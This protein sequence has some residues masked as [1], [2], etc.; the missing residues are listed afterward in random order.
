VTSH[1]PIDD[2]VTLAALL[3]DPAQVDNL[4]PERAAALLAQLAT[5]QDALFARMR[6]VVGP[7]EC[8]ASAATRQI[9]PTAA[10]SESDLMTIDEAAAM[11]R[12]NPRWLYRHA[13][14]LP[15][16]RKLSR[17]VLRFSRTGA[18]KWLATKRP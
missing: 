6:A 10:W 4:P 9:A 13:K 7:E 2:D 14:Q 3:G 17:K 8:S 12:L 11:L 1:E 16:A 18:A 15:F 5:V